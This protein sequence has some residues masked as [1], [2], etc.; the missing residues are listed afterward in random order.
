MINFRNIFNPSYSYFML[1]FILV[2]AIIIC[3]VNQ[4]IKT[5]L[6]TLGKTI[7]ISGIITLAFALL[8]ELGINT[9]ITYNYKIFVKVISN[10]LFV[11]L[12]YSA[13]ISIVIGFFFL[14][15]SKVEFKKTSQIK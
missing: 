15:L 14:V 1:I 9:L 2:L 8:I 3:L 10:S 6:N 4:N 11:S 12:L 13:V 7:L 5:S